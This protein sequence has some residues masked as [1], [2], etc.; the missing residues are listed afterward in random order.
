MTQPALVQFFTRTDRGAVRIVALYLSLG[1][2]WIL[3]SDRLLIALVPDPALFG[4]LNLL[5]GWAFIVVTALFLYWLIQRHTNAMQAGREWLRLAFDAGDFGT[6][7]QDLTSGE[8]Q[9]DE[10][11]CRTYGFDASP[12]PFA[13]LLARVYPDDVARAEQIFH[14]PAGSNATD[15]FAG[16][17][18]IV[19]PETGIRWVA[20]HGRI[21]SP[22]GQRP[23]RSRLGVGT[24]QDITAR[25]EVEQILRRYEL[26]VESSRDIILFVRRDGRILDANRAAF[27]AY[28]YSCAELINRPIQDL[29]PPEERA[30]LEAQM[31]QA[32]REGI[33]F[34]TVHQRRDGSTFPVQVS[35]RGATISGERVLLS[36]IRDITE[37]K[38]AENALRAGEAKYRALAENSQQGIAIFQGRKLVYANPAHCRMFGYSAQ[39]LMAMSE[40]ELLGLVH[41]D[42]RALGQARADKRSNDE[43]LP[44]DTQ[45]RILR[46]DGSVC[47]VQ[48]F[49]STIEYE[50]QPALLSTNIDI[51]ERKRAAD[52][53]RES[54]ERYRTL[55]EHMLNGVAHC[56]MLI[57]DGAPLDFVYL[58]VNDAFQ[59][60]TGLEN[61]IG[62]RVSE[63]I[64]GIADTNP[65][66]LELYARVSLTGIPERFETFVPQLRSGTWFSIAVYS[67]QRE[68]F[69]AVFDVITER[70]RAE[71]SLREIADN[72]AMA[73]R[74][75]HV[76]SWEM[77]LSDDNQLLGPALWSDECYRIFG[78]EPRAVEPTQE[79]FE[80]RVLPEDL[81]N[82]LQPRLDKG[83]SANG[84]P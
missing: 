6:W 51:T 11:A 26:L 8:I 79:F 62:R 10:T 16:E 52:A 29:R 71:Q 35:L 64:P 50:G 74:I 13:D 66:L 76:G 60:L 67:P 17:Y 28:G 58:T 54:E 73:Q 25:K 12:I 5:K 30:S 53:L 59:N 1:G 45:L 23:P 77:A 78:F 48:L 80:S 43:S 21:H 61:V 2:L 3:F 34:E 4:F 84:V 55:F 83:V 24:I 56:R 19:H 20:V 33:L 70:K 9:L 38:R 82:T 69:V 36:I 22:P 65:E 81:A 42:D 14:P 63:L 27:H 41:P 7:Q 37:S 68:H 72:M 15:R 40:Q 44:A 75:G 47:W 32:E 18:R 39:E 46:K 49:T 57:Q 31:T